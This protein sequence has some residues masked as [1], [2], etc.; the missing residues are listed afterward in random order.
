MSVQSIYGATNSVPVTTG[1]TTEK[2]DKTNENL[3]TAE[4][5]SGF[6]ET[7]VVYEK[8]P[9]SDASVTKKNNTVFHLECIFSRLDKKKMHQ[10]CC[11]WPMHQYELIY[12]L[13]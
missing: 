11:L 8:T 1:N 7:A 13:D 12:L 10:P 3:T 2:K 5:K 9:A 6:D 4:G